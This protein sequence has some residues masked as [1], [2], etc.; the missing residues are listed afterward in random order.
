MYTNIETLFRT[1]I[2][3]N[4][5]LGWPIVTLVPSC[6]KPTGFRRAWTCFSKPC[7][8]IPPRPIIALGTALVLT[9]RTSE[10]INH[11]KQALRID[12]DYAEAYNNMGNALFL[13]GR[14]SEAIAQYK[15]AL[16]SYPDYANAHNNLGNALVQMG[17]ISEAI[18]HYKQ[19]LRMNPGSRPRTTILELPW[20]RSAKIPRRSNKSKLPYE[21]SPTI[22]M[23]ETI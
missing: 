22:S 7:E 2:A 17:R 8:S 11:F 13:T 21:S 14:T 6:F 20:P 16:Q 9:G 1:T 4:P 19:A 3:R 12:P 10:A 15:Q 5:L 23:P 18:G